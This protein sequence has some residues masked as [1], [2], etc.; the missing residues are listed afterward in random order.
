MINVRACDIC[1]APLGNQLT[2]LELVR[3]AVSFLP[4]DRWSVEPSPGG[5]RVRM[6]CSD[7]D[8]YLREAVQHLVSM[9]SPEARDA[10]RDA[11]AAQDREAGVGR[12]VA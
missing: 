12:S 10:A 5:M 2:R 6:V 3:G 9:V 11:R 7:C 1:Q 4:R 8:Q